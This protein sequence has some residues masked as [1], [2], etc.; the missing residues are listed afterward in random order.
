MLGTGLPSI[1]LMTDSR[2]LANAL[3]IEPAARR[4][5]IHLVDCQYYQE[6]GWV[7]RGCLA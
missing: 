6:Y 4:T 3:A 5:L 1:S 2:K 7:V